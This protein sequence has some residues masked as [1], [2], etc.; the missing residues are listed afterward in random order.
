MSLFRHLDAEDMA[1]IM[2]AEF[3]KD[4]KMEQ[5]RLPEIFKTPGS[6]TLKVETNPKVATIGEAAAKAL[7]YLW[8]QEQYTRI[9]VRYG[10]TYLVV[11]KLKD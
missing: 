4:R 11:A 9:E 8:S 3:N 2:I 7:D 1:R 5:M 10:K 6:S